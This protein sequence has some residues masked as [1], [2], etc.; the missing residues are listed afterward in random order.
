MRVGVLDLLAPSAPK[1]LRPNLSY[2]LLRKQYAS[3]MPQAVSVWAREAGHETFYATYH[4]QKEPHK[5]LPDD[6]DI[7]FIASYTQSS[8][9]AYALAKLYRAAG[10]RTVLGGPHARSFPDDSLR[11][12][13]N[14]VTQ[15]DRTL[16][17][18]ILRLDHDAGAVLSTDRPLT[19]LPSIEQR[20]PEIRRAYFFRGQPSRFTVIGLLSSVGC[21]YNCNFCL[22]WNNP[23]I[24]L[25][26]EHLERD[27]RFM[28][29]QFPGVK[30]GFHDPNF[31][32]KFDDVLNVMER[33][34][35]RSRNPYLMESSLS[36]LRGERLKRLRD[37]N[38]I[39]AAPGVESWGSYSNKSG[40]GRAGGNEK[41]TRL[42][43]QFRQLHEAVPGIQANFIFGIDVDEGDEP[44]TLTKEFMERAP[45]V[46][47]AINI[48]SPFGGTPL[49][50]QYLE[51]GRIL[52]AM[53]FLFYYAP[54][55]A[56]TLKHYRPEEYYQKL[57]ELTAAS[58]S[59][60][61]WAKRM[62]AAGSW[63]VGAVT[64]L[65]TAGQFG[66]IGEYRRI[67]N[68]LRT[69][70]EFR[71]FH[72]GESEAL[73][74]FYHREY[75]RVL[76]PYATLLSREDRTPLFVRRPVVREAAPLPELSVPRRAGPGTAAETED[77]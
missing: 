63:E 62:A 70:S 14:V 33:I 38:C 32:I 68:L 64:S 66:K 16:V 1:R 20:L 54:Y 18:D 4:G 77:W 8:P 35:R 5:L 34:P 22:D 39:F 56:I 44:V 2:G 75:D 65:R 15:C 60:A 51:E 11:F 46:W 29:E 9:M 17:E 59:P 26:P 71:A 58:C 27:L 13:D 30:I 57:V 7:V 76:G 19:E 42:V 50:D 55:L 41:L 53:P 61:L 45:F 69:D 52:R 48:P 40:V 74:E 37:T 47:P 21:P 73:P 3:I 67:L 28:S 31:A 36:V 12:F 25:P 72:E 49:Y 6:L 23:Y 43:E 10:V 24:V